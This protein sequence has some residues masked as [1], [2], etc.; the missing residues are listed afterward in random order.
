MRSGENSIRNL[1]KETETH[2]EVLKHEGEGT[3]DFDSLQVLSTEEV[4]GVLFLRY[5][6]VFRLRR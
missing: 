5:R 3:S 4:Q 1:S 6:E 2:L